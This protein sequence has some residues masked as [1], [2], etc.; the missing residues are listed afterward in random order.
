MNHLRNH[1]WL[2]SS[3]L[4]SALILCLLS[5]LAS[6]SSFVPI[7]KTD[8]EAA[9][10]NQSA[11][12]LLV[13]S[14]L[15]DRLASLEL[16]AR[17]ATGQ[18]DIPASA[19][20]A[21]ENYA[22]AVKSGAPG[23]ASL[24]GFVS[25][26]IR[27]SRAAAQP[28]N[29]E[30]VPLISADPLSGDAPLAV[31][32]DASASID[33]GF[34]NVYSWRFGNGD[35]A[36]GVSAS[37]DYT[38]PGVYRTSLT[39][40]DDTGQVTSTSLDIQVNVSKPAVPINTSPAVDAKL[41]QG[42]EATFIWAPVA[43]ADSYDF[44]FFDNET[45]GLTFSN[46]LPAADICTTF[47]SYTTTVNLPVFVDHAWRVRARNAAGVSSW[48]RSLFDMVEQDFEPEPEV[49]FP[50]VIV[51]A[52]TDFSG[53][54]PF[55]VALDASASNDDNGIV[56]Y[57]WLLDGVAIASG[58]AARTQTQ[59]LE[60]EGNYVFTLTVTDTNSQTT[61]EVIN[62]T[63]IGDQPPVANV[64]VD[65]FGASVAGLAPLTIV[66]SGDGSADDTNIT[67]Y[68]WD[69]GDGSDT[70]V[71]SDTTEVTHTYTEPG[72]YELALTVADDSDQTDTKTIAVR[73]LT[74]DNNPVSARAAARLLTQATFGTRA[75]DIAQ[76]QQLGVDGWLNWQF[77]LQG[78]PHL[79]Y[80]SD[81]SNGSLRDPRHEIWWKDV[82]DGDDQ[83]RQRVAFALSQ[84]F[85]ISDVG[86]TLSNAQY[87]VTHYYDQLRELAFGNYRDL[88]ETV[89][90]S[91]VM[92]IYLSMLQ[93]SKGSDDGSTRPDENFA[94]EV[95]QL[96][97]VG[98][99]ELNEDGTPTDTN[100]YTQ[101]HVEAYARVFTGW[102]YKDA[103]VWD[104]R[105]FTNQDLIN[106]MEPMEAFHDKA[107]K[108]LLGGVVA[109]AGI[110]ATE[111]LAI[112]L[113]SIFNHSNVGPFIG[114][115]LIQRL[116]TSNPSPAYVSRVTAAF[117]DNGEGVRGDLQ[118]VVRA[119]LTDPEARELDNEEPDLNAIPNDF[120][121]LREPV[122]RLSH[123]W[124]A[125]D[126]TRGS[127]SNEQREDYNTYSP[128]KAN[129]DLA[130]GQA[131]L[132]SP[133]V[134][135]FYHP[136]HRPSGAAFADSNRVAPEFE[137]Y[138]DS[139]Q[140]L[141][142]TRINSQIQRHYLGTSN[143]SDLNPSY[144]DYSGAQALLSVDSDDQVDASALLDHLDTILLSGLMSDA[145]RSI[146]QSHMNALP[147]DDEGL[148]LR[149]RDGVSLIMAS[150]EYLIQR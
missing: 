70:V 15:S 103:G 121:K 38:D 115:Q 14:Q 95:L 40:M 29:D 37:T 58:P 21:L 57:E 45:K 18:G 106:P 5:P 31:L 114:K 20:R 13:A 72:E 53:R 118:A 78:P 107:S 101:D 144:L 126:I 8:F 143:T 30:P 75:S 132:R 90:L 33:D 1:Y 22:V 65:G 26:P 110:S 83:L 135:N 61:S 28:F 35:T 10:G 43:Y 105:L 74:P 2:P 52:D 94:R 16:A 66:A 32:F 44:H 104:R 48:S 80:V 49:D 76:V 136:D 146:L 100:A 145:L 36:E 17:Y 140:L 27:A 7:D 113:D 125:F 46:G 117:N 55:T 96:F 54:V 97:S 25:L 122:L 64:A 12:S 91:P 4:M 128:S 141:T 84:I 98:L 68:S 89:T 23:T 123:L 6:A 108:V 56:N 42:L 150:P 131:V 34:I 116:V 86:Y 102:N 50:P 9:Y 149:V 133:S 60:T 3:S 81:Y 47:C 85:V 71:G 119:I 73:V 62:V 112:A 11:A 124:R 127:R 138:T 79:D 87:G 129:L 41:R 134:F 69:F 63:A 67:S 142:T 59:L 137:I 148:S 139:N 19:A 82:V 24:S 147:A 120:G 93:N 130:T 88:L 77:S 111:D 39:V 109:P 51:I 92:G 99:Y